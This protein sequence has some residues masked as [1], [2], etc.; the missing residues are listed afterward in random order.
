MVAAAGVWGVV[1]D[2]VGDEASVLGEGDLILPISSI[3]DLEGYK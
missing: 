3:V 2:E 1:A